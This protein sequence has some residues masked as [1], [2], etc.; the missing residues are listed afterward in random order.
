M[1]F[2]AGLH[3]NIRTDRRGGREMGDYTVKR[4]DEMEAIYGGIV[5][6][7]RA[8]LGVSAFG[9]QVMDLPPGWEGYPNHDHVNDFFDDNDLRQE[10][11]YIALGG[12]ATLR[13]D[14]EA[15]ELEPGVLVRVGAG[16]KRQL[17][18][19]PK[20]FRMVAVGGRPGEAYSPPAWTELG[21]PLPTG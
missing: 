3:L 6:R 9:M 16:Q 7:A 12:S 13:V 21:G 11:V 4:V 14:E 20:G 10:E 17:V 1:S 15:H 5:R 2:R 18:P 8:G 19:G